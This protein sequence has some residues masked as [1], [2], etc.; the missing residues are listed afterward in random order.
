MQI[1]TMATISA[2]RVTV[3]TP[4]AS[5][6]RTGGLGPADPSGAAGGP[7]GLAVLGAGGSAGVTIRG[8]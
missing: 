1:G 6:E 2:T 3:A 5:Q 8:R 7:D 4:S